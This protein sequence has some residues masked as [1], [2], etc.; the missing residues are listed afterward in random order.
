MTERWTNY[1][2][3]AKQLFGKKIP[4]AA[5]TVILRDSKQ[6]LYIAAQKRQLCLR[7]GRMVKISSDEINIREIRSCRMEPFQAQRRHH[8]GA[9]LLIDQ[10]HPAQDMPA[11]VFPG[12]ED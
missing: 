4:D 2:G 10:K 3:S 1:V 12:M 7:R 5:G 11:N 6:G 8:P 9:V